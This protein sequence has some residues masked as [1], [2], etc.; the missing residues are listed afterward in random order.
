MILKH[1][2]YIMIVLNLGAAMGIIGVV[3]M[4]GA[5]KKRDK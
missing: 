3:W 1:V 4:Q 5:T 2:F